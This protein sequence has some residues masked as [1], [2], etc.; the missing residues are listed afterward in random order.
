MNGIKIHLL[1]VWS[2]LLNCNVN[3][4]R[5]IDIFRYLLGFCMFGGMFSACMPSTDDIEPVRKVEIKI[6]LQ[7][8]D[9][10]DTRFAN[11]E[12]TIRG[13]K[14]SY[15]AVTD[16]EGVAV[17]QDLLPDVY[18]LAVSYVLPR[19]EYGNMVNPP[20]E[21]N[22]VL[23]N[24]TLPNLRIY[25]NYNGE[26]TLQMGVRQ[27]LIF[28]KIYYSGTKNAN[29]K[30]YDVDQYIELYNNSDQTVSTENI[31]I[32]LLETESTPWFVEEKEQYIYAKDIFKLPT[33]D[34]E[35]G[36]SILIARQAIDHTIDAPLSLDLTIA[37]YEVKAV[38]KPQNSQVEQLPHV[39]K[40]LATLDW[41]NMVVGGGNQL[42]LF[43]YDGDVNDLTKKQKP[44]AKP[45][46]AWYVQIATSMVLDGVECL[47]YNAQEIDLSK[48]RMPARIDASYQTLSTA[49][50][51]T[52]ESIERKVARVEENGRVVLQDTNN[53]LEDFVCTSDIRPMV[54]TK[55][56]LQPQV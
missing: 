13:S 32:A 50:G 47:K 5:T 40:S 22:D 10:I 44:D 25:E 52:G 21:A 56:E 20:I 19:E 53:S 16:E 54:Y 7:E 4:M 51:R 14:N 43:R 55:P 29:N 48:K 45:S 42:V 26:L 23:L 1:L 46:H 41:L 36:K 37:D 18:S 31:H 30:N 33:R 2:F 17:F 9:F 35:P 28:S 27:S 49:S 8:E 38:N 15:K 6:S 3:D 34:L 12:V 24:G 11:K 39:Y